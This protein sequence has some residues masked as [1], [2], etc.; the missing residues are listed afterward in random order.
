MTKKIALYPGTFDPLTYGH[1]DV[2]KRAIQIVDTLYVGIAHNK[3]KKTLFNAKE[4]EDIISK[5]L[6]L[7]PTPVSYTHLTLPT[8]A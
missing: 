2:I 8:K 5:T 4:R 3:N 6:K 1:L 7:L